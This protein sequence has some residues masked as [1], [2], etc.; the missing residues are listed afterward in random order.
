MQLQRLDPL[1]VA[2]VISPVTTLAAWR[3]TQGIYRFD[4]TLYE[5][6]VE[7]SLT[8][9]LP[10]EALFRL[11]E[12]CLYI[13]TPGLQVMRRDYSRAELAGT[14]AR[15]DV[16][17]DGTRVLILTMDIPESDQPQAH[18]LVL[19]G[20]LQ[21]AVEEIHAGWGIRNP[22]A[23]QGVA[24]YLRPIINMLLYLCGTEDVMGPAG[25]PGNPTPQRTKRGEKLFP[26]SSAKSWDV[27]V[28]MGAALR[29]AYHERETG[30]GTH[31]GPR[32]HVRRAHWH[33]FRTGPLKRP[34]GSE[35]PAQERPLA[36]KWLPP[37]PINMG[38]PDELPATIRKVTP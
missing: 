36:V 14:W 27:G 18:S 12:W 19:K 20:S 26:A 24:E 3:M 21:S 11:P 32:P 33:G 29:R 1:Q 13:E 30:Q 6:L 25:T 4:P 37:I 9:D 2:S 34:D 10:A 17:E 28:R 16:E 22:R 35:I 31:A 15:V 5:T 23:A 7:T 8:G 38:S